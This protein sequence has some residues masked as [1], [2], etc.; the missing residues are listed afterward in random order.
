MKIKFNI[1]LIN[2]TLGNQT[3]ASNTLVG[4]WHPNW[5]QGTQYVYTVHLS[6]SEAGMEK[7][8]FN[9]GVT[10]WNNPDSDNVPEKINISLDYVLTTASEE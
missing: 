10:D 6:G 4:S 2:P 9:V 8:E 7:I 3:I 5:R 1:R